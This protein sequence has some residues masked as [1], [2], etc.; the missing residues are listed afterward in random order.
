SQCGRRTAGRDDDVDLLFDQFA[1]MALQIERL[2]VASP[3]GDDTD[4]GAVNEPIHA[5]EKHVVMVLERSLR[6]VMKKSDRCHD[7]SSLVRNSQCR[8]RDAVRDA[9]PHSNTS[10]ARTR[11]CGGTSMPKRL[12]AFWLT[13][14]SN[15]VGCI[16]GRSAGF[17]PL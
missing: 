7:Q 9:H 3:P 16:T 8:P 1:D 13:T 14:S 10:S 5:V 12:A 6:L 15:R 17:S 4:A 11:I 2:V